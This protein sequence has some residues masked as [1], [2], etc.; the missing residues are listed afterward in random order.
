MHSAHLMLAL[1]MVVAIGFSVSTHRY[2]GLCA[3]AV[4][5]AAVN[6]F[7]MEPTYSFHVSQRGDMAALSLYS[8][9]GMVVA[10]R[11]ESES[12]RPGAWIKRARLNLR[13]RV[14]AVPLDPYHLALLVKLSTEINQESAVPVDP[15]QIL[16]VALRRLR[17]NVDA[18][19]TGE[20]LED[21]RLQLAYEEWISQLRSD[22]DVP[23]T[24]DR[25]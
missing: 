1:M 10:M 20:I 8:I 17:Q 25:L 11:K 3:I 13:F 5:G 7:L 2:L 9:F 4:G 14:R 6:Y 22:G 23:S 18:E 16:S 19:G 21:V 24:Q 15:G 12:H